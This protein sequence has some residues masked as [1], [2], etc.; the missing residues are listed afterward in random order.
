MDEAQA[1]EAP[2]GGTNAIDSMV[3]TVEN[4]KTLQSAGG[5]MVTVGR[6][7]AW[8]GLIITTLVSLVLVY[9]A[10]MMFNSQKN[11]SIAST[12]KVTAAKTTT[13]SDQNGTHVTTT[14]DFEYDQDGKKYS[15]T[16]KTYP[17][18]VLVGETVD[19]LINDK[20]PSIAEAPSSA[21]NIGYVLVGIAVF[22]TAVSAGVLYA[23]YY[24]RWFAGLYGTY[25]GVKTL[26]E[27]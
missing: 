12:A 18:V 9:F 16:G 5:F 6:T 14:V 11:F 23:T 22:I 20:D 24:S 17:G 10:R 7:Y 21:K 25:E 19:I 1:T 15:A 3:S 13:T 2:P 8:V 4:S 26:K 27:L